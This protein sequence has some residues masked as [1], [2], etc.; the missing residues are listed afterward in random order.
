MC[1]LLGKGDRLCV[2]WDTEVKRITSLYVFQ[3]MQK[4]DLNK[5]VKVTLF[6]MKILEEDVS[7]LTS[8]CFFFSLF[9]FLN[10][11]SMMTHFQETWKNRTKLHIVPL[12]ITIIF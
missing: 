8:K 7:E 2:V 6:I 3:G 10:Y 11:E 9:Y 4:S 5:Y 12:Y 1:I